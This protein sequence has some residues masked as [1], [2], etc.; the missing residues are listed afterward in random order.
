MIHGSRTQCSPVPC[1]DRRSAWHNV[2]RGGVGRKSRAH[3]SCKVPSF[4][5]GARTENAHVNRHRH[6][7]TV[8]FH[9]VE[10][11]FFH[12]VAFFTSVRYGRQFGAGRS[13]WNVASIVLCFMCFRLLRPWNV[14]RRQRLFPKQMQNSFLTDMVSHLFHIFVVVLFS[15]SG[16]YSKFFFRD[17]TVSRVMCIGLRGAFYAGGMATMFCELHISVALTFQFFRWHRSLMLLK[18]L[19]PCIWPSAFGLGAVQMLFQQRHLHPNMDTGVCDSNTEWPNFSSVLL[20]T[21]V[22][23][24]CSYFLAARASNRA[25]FSFAARK[26]RIAKFYPLNVVLTTGGYAAGAVWSPL[27]DKRYVR[28]GATA[29]MSLNGAINALTYSLQSRYANSATSRARITTQTATHEDM[30]GRF[31]FSSDVSVASFPDV[32]LVLRRFG[33]VFIMSHI[34]NRSIH[35]FHRHEV[36]G[37]ISNALKK[38]LSRCDV[39][40][41]SHSHANKFMYS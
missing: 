21:I 24:L 33:T 31:C 2:C 25:P 13:R 38:A 34:H 7:R 11:K 28:L 26:W 23:S 32:E 29:G 10:I 22:I 27:W 30:M 35:A 5:H 20:L 16:G 36:D 19:I 4:D 37:S 12:C 18:T 39:Q 17:E 15:P 3:T 6:A 40:P 14:D 9:A 1:G 41:H 8:V